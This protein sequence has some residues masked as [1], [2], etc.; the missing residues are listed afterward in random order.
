MSAADL[1]WLREA[2]NWGEWHR[3]PGDQPGV[4]E[5]VWMMRGAN[6]TVRFYAVGRGQVGQRHQSVVAAT[7]WAWANGWLWTEPDG[8]IDMAGQLACREWVAAGGAQP[9]G[10]G[11]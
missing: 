1:R 9:A 7:A 8:S 4:P 2:E 10:A 6:G 11:A 3:V 5:S